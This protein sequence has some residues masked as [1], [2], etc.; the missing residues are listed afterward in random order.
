VNFYP[1]TTVTLLRTPA[2]TQDSFG[3]PMDNYTP[4]VSGAWTAIP[5]SII[6]QIQNTSRPD[7]TDPKTIRGYNCRLPSEVPVQDGD[8]I[9]DEQTEVI[10]M[11]D[12]ISKVANPARQMDWRL[13][14]RDVT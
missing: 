4:A 14:L 10:Y 1:T 13:V 9:E 8:R 12:T 11:I 3:D 6:E 2:G 5:A 7:S